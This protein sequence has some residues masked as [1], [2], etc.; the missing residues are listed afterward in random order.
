MSDTGKTHPK[1]LA[2]IILCDLHVLNTHDLFV[3]KHPLV[4]FR[5]LFSR[6]SGFLFVPELFLRI[7]EIDE[8]GTRG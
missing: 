5:E 7:A 8:P 6:F 1:Y 3:G 2:L 4:L